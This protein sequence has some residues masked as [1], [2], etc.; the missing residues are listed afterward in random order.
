MLKI[1]FFVPEKNCEKVK[2]AMFSAGAGKFG[3]YDCCS[4]QSKGTGQFR[5]LE[6]AKPF[7]GEIGKIEK[8]QEIK[9]EMICADECIEEV[10]KAM[11]KAHPYEEVAFEV[12]ELFRF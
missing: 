6:N 10:I 3:K 2:Q 12:T 8:V 5:P 9:V 11:K 7:V 1:V 4:F